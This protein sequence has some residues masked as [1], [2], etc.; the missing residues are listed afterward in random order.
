MIIGKL[1]E[2]QVGLRELRA[3]HDEGCACAN[4]IISAAAQQ[5]WRI[6]PNDMTKTQPG[7]LVKLA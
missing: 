5:I 6:S 4:H 1:C 3:F 7:K 2:T